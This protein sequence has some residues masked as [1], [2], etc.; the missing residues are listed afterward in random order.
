MAEAPGTGAPYSDSRF[1]FSK[2]TKDFFSQEV[3]ALRSVH[4]LES[5]EE[6]EKQVSDDILISRVEFSQVEIQNNGEEIVPLLFRYLLFGQLVPASRKT[7]S[8]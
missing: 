4:H 3:F 5:D 8:C 7:T 1:D 6:I 2:F